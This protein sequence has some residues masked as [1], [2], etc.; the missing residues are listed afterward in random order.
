MAGK[1]WNS[2]L[3]L[4]EMKRRLEVR[5]E[6]EGQKCGAWLDELAEGFACQRHPEEAPSVEARGDGGEIRIVCAPCRQQTR[7]S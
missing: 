7:M 1:T 6:R 2:P 4:D 3:P 5:G